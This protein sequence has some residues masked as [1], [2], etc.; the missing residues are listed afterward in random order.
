[1]KRQ[2]G[3]TFLLRIWRGGPEDAE[4]RATLES[5]STGRRY[6]FAALEDLCAWIRAG[7]EGAEGQAAQ[8]STE[9]PPAQPP[10]EGA[11][12]TPG[13]LEDRGSARR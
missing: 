5:A 8:R 4:W 6:G 12:D 1:M 10:D 7:A 2:T 13:P 9:E 3:W 11:G